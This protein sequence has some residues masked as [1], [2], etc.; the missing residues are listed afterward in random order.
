MIS[1]ARTFGAP[2]IVPAG[3]VARISTLPAGDV[4]SCARL[5]FNVSELSQR[6]AQPRS[7][8][9]SPSAKS[10]G[11]SNICTTDET[12]WSVGIF[13]DGAKIA[14]PP[15]TLTDVWRKGDGPSSRNRAGRDS[16]AKNPVR[17]ESE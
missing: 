7:D 3:N 4:S 17:P 10:T 13:F 14:S 1:M 9:G 16:G 5:A 2:V 12:A 15:Q 11:T 6:M 8:D